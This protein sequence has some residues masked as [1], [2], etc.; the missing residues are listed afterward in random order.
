MTK[1]IKRVLEIIERL[2]H[3]Q[4]N[5]FALTLNRDFLLRNIGYSEAISDLKKAIKKEWKNA[6][7]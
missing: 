7:F 5:E 2:K 4:V 1:E 6:T 3:R